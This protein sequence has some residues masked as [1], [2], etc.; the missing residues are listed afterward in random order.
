[1]LFILS[2]IASLFSPT[3]AE[4]SNIRRIF[5]CRGVLA[6]GVLVKV[7]LGNSF[8]SSGGWLGVVGCFF[9]APWAVSVE[10]GGFFCVALFLGVTT[11]VSVSLSTTSNGIANTCP[12]AYLNPAERALFALLSPLS[13]PS[14]TTVAE[15]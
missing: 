14:E 5:S 6:G 13:A 12:T 10:M 15:T 1:M 3:L 4:N 9:D 2:F 8:F 11:G 7:T